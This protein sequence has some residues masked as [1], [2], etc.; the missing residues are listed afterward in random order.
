[1]EDSESIV[2]CA[3]KLLQSLTPSHDTYETSKCVS[4]VSDVII[5][6]L[7]PARLSVGARN[8]VSYNLFKAVS[9]TTW[10]DQTMADGDETPDNG[11]SLVFVFKN[12]TLEAE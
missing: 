4:S 2:D 1:M 6:Q 9:L 10:N 12:G 5:T 7:N 8:V 3:Y 11:M